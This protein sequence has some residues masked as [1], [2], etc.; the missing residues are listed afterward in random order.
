ME[1]GIKLCHEHMQRLCPHRFFH[2]TNYKDLSMEH[3][4]VSARN[5]SYSRSLLFSV[6]SELPLATLAH[7]GMLQ[8]SAHRILDSSEH[9]VQLQSLNSCSPLPI[10]IHWRPRGIN[11]VRDKLEGGRVSAC[12]AS[13]VFFYQEVCVRTCENEINAART[14]LDQ[15]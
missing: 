9:C 14:R 6:S 7:P 12:K 1:R 8:S 2:S 5:Y 15:N 11:L 13:K 3:Y 4:L 10:H